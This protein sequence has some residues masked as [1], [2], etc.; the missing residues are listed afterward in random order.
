ML[1]RSVDT[2]KLLISDQLEG[3]SGLMKTLAG[4]VDTMISMDSARERR[5]LDELSSNNII[6]T[7]AV[8]YERDARTMM[9]TL[10]VRDEDADKLKLQAIASKICGNKMVINDVTPTE[11]AGLVAVNLKTAPRYDCIFGLASA[12]K[13]GGGESGDRHSIERLDGDRFIFAICDGM[14]SGAQAGKKAETTIGLIENFYKAGF[15][16][17]IILS[18][19]NRLMNLES[20]DI[21]SS[22]DIC[23]VDLKDGIADFIKM[24]AT[25]SYVRGEEGCKIVECSA[26]PVGILDNAKAYTKKIV[27]QNKDN[28]ILCSD[29]I[30]DAFGSDGEFKDFLL[31][32]KAQ[33]PQEYADR[34]SVV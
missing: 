4:E 21:F 6:C 27:L 7:D 28:I 32:V 19:V 8:V 25:T 15:E 18:S 23:I 22:I 12:A 16:S 30:N 33:N 34:K 1:F 17:E 10:V 14:G 13:G 2:S 11:R 9:A 3:I 24:G 5:I 26:L 20:S 29:G 31:T